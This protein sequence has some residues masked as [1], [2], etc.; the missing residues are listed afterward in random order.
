MGMRR[1]LEKK[2]DVSLRIGLSKNQLRWI[3]VDME[4]KL[5]DVPEWYP[6]WTIWLSGDF[7]DP[8]TRK[9]K[10][11]LLKAL[12]GLKHA[13]SRPGPLVRKSENFR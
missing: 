3:G 4:G 12:E 1:I 2:K 10:S 13:P 5:G 11:V 8:R 6:N 7:S 9:K